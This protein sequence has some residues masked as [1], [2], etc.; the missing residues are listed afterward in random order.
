MGLKTDFILQS[1]FGE[2]DIF[3]EGVWCKPYSN[4][5]IWGVS[6]VVPNHELTVLSLTRVASVSSSLLGIVLD[7]RTDYG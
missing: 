1:F 2:G 5:G 3:K 7:I 6:D 4:N